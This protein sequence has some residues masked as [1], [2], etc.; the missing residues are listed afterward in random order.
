MLLPKFIC[1]DVVEFYPSIS[2]ALLIRALD[3]ASEHVNISADERLTIINSKHSLLFSKGHPWVKK[4]SRSNFDVTMGSYDGA[5]TCELVGCYLLAQLKQIPGIEI[6]LYRDDGLAILNQTPREIEKAKKQICQVFTN[7]NLKITVEANKKI[8][9][10]LDVTLDLNTGKFKPYSKPSSTPLY[11]HSQSNHPPNI[12][13]NIPEAINRRLSCIS[14][15]QE[16]FDEAAAP[17]QEALRKSG[18]TFKLEFKPPPQETPSQKRKRRRNVIWFNPPYNKNIKNNIGREF[19]S[20]IERSF[21]SGHKLRKIFNRNTLKLSYSCMPSVKQIIDGHNKAILKKADTTTLQTNEGKKCNCRKKEDCPLNG[22][23][24]VDEVVY[25]ATV[26][27]ENTT[28]T[29]IG[30]TANNFKAR[31]GNHQMSFRHE[32]RKSETELSKHIWQLK[33]ENKEFKVTWK[34]LA[35]A[36][37]YTNITKRCDLCS[38]EKFFLT[39]RPHMATL[40]KRNELISTCRHRRKFILRFNS[41]RQRH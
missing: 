23:C 32:K 12:I 41:A 29:Y 17:Y 6:G 2:E 15:D 31:Y 14:S 7:N 18:Y 21:P 20:L 11:V 30:L 19:I 28:E 26:T 22:E 4:N 39:C 9:N 10:F 35:K 13:R 40:N 34:I 33:G 1:F 3:F 37:P 36:K 8:V 16:V 27:T 5:E 24:M 38:T 25:Q